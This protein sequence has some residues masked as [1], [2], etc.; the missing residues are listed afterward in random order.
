MQ[1]VADQASRLQGDTIPLIRN[2]MQS[3]EDILSEVQGLGVRGSRPSQASIAT[4][5]THMISLAEKKQGEDLSPSPGWGIKS[6]D[7]ATGGVQLREL[8][9]IAARPSMGKTTVGLS[10]ALGMAEAGH[11]VLF[12]SLEMDREK[13]GARA[14]SNI[15]Y[16]GPKPVP[17]INLIRGNINGH[18]LRLAREACHKLEKLPLVIDDRP[19]PSLAEIRLRTERMAEEARQRGRPLKA[20]II[21]HLGLIRPSNRYQGNRNNEISEITAGLKALARELDIAVILLSQLNR[22]VEGRTKKIPQ[23]ADLRDSGAIEQDSDTIIF[24]HREAYY[25]SREIVGTIDE[26]FERRDRLEVVAKD[27]DCI[28]SKQRNGPIG[29]LTLFT[30]MA[31]SVVREGVGE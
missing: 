8:T 1:E 4:A 27:M 22:S 10:V 26:H 5:A 12:F 14:I 16:D 17:Y 25:L 18:D 2:A 6:L 15:L 29:S 23:L 11:P 24:L 3:L 21:D 28:I 13:L 31:F 30:D 7:H 20:V 19:F 9:L